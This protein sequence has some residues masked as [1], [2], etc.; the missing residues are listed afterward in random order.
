MPI[1]AQRNGRTITIQDS[2]R[3]P[4]EIFSRVM[5]YL[6]PITTDGYKTE[7]WNKGKVSEWKERVF[8]NINKTISQYN[9]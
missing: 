6:R 3:I 9:I 5:G 7:L 8:F 2:E 1:T 4:C